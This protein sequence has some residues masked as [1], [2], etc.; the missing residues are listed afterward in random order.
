[1]RMLAGLVAVLLL[2]GGPVSEAECGPG[3]HQFAHR[4]LAEP[5]CV[6]DDPQRV[7]F[8]DSNIAFAVALDIP[9]VTTSYYSSVMVQDFP[10]VAGRLDPKATDV[11]NT[12]EMNGELLLLA[13]PDLVVTSIYWHAANGFARA[14]APTVAID[15][16][17]ATSWREVP[18]L[19]AELFGK[20]A[21]QQALD[22]ALDAR[23][24]AF[25]AALGDAP[26]T[27]T[28]VQVESPTQLWLFTS[29]TFGAELALEAGLRFAPQVLAPEAAAK[30]AQGGPFAYPVSLE[31]IDQIDADHIFVYAMTG[32]DARK[33]LLET[34]IGARFAE[35]HARELHFLA[36]EYW[37]NASAFAAQRVLDDLIRDV[38]G[39]APGEVSPNPLAWSY[40][41]AR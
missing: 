41:V 18:A 23:L 28:F 7:A 35:L 22:A 20:Q 9:S 2:A 24:V 14:L 11:G 12:W 6:P 27:F 21:E 8:I 13:D 34:P 37:F 31:Q 3:T 26:A 10:G 30:V 15:P 38:L 25:R 39:R 1:M 36:G 17:K 29:K 19:V 16:D 5:V 33:M 40:T 32:S 4:L